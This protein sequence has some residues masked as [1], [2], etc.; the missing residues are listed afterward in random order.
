MKK[1]ASEAPSGRNRLL[2]RSNAPAL[3]EADQ[4][5]DEATISRMWIKPPIV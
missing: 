4:D 1:S 3:H 5:H 2:L